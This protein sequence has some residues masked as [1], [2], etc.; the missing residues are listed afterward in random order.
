MDSLDSFLFSICNGGLLSK[1][2]GSLIGDLKASDLSHL[3][4]ILKKL[5]S[6]TH[7]QPMQQATFMES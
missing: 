6:S 1:E 2:P 3:L 4:R 5:N 7:K